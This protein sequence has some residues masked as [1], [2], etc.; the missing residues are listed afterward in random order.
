MNLLVDAVDRGRCPADVF[1]D[2]AVQIGIGPA[3]V[4]LAQGDP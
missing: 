2:T 4:A 1:A 3:T